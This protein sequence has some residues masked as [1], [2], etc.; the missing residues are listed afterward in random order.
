MTIT[1]PNDERVTFCATSSYGRTTSVRRFWR[2]AATI[3]SNDRFAARC[4]PAVPLVTYGWRSRRMSVESTALRSNRFTSAAT[5]PRTR[6]PSMFTPSGTAV[7]G[8]A[9][10]AR[11]T[12]FFA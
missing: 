6:E 7:P 12:A 8:A 3:A 9:T 2:S 10:R 5:S 1:E 4:F 11:E